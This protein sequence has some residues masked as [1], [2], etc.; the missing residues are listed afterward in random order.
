MNADEYQRVAI[1]QGE[2]AAEI[3]RLREQA[4][5]H[6]RAGNTD[7]VNKL[8]CLISILESERTKT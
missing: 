6:L 8:L 5:L 1:R 7:A 3:F 4:D 2:I